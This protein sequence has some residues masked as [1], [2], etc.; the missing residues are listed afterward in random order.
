MTPN[1]FVPRTH[2]YGKPD[3]LYIFRIDKPESF[4]R[5]DFAVFF[6]SKTCVNIETSFF[7]TLPAHDVTH[8]RTRTR[9][10]TS[11]KRYE[12]GE[13]KLRGWGTVVE[14]YGGKKLNLLEAYV[15]SLIRR[16]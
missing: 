8:P 6:E 5:Q 11:E 7:K 15:V 9:S 2:I 4:H 10:V 1:D 13:Q 3:F 16:G 12:N 14:M